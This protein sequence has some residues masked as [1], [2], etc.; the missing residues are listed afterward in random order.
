MHAIAWCLRLAQPQAKPGGCAS[1]NVPYVPPVLQLEGLPHA[2]IVAIS[3]SC[4][5]R[6]I[7][8][9]M[10]AAVGVPCLPKVLDR[11]VAQAS[12]RQDDVH[13]ARLRRT[14]V[15]VGNEQLE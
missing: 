1:A 15:A 10:T 4:E 13:V 5:S 2:C 8:I 7:L 9:P 6:C 11:Q 14:R 12:C 3:L